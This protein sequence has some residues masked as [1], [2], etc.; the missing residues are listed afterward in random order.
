MR[1][2]A[3]SRKGV[4][5]RS[6]SHLGTEEDVVGGL[7]AEHEGVVLVAHLILVAAEAAAAPDAG[8]AQP[9]Q[10]LLQDTVTRKARRGV[11]M[12]QPP[13]H[14]T[15]LLQYPWLLLDP[16]HWLTTLACMHAC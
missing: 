8:R 13:G 16:G 15:L 9:R 3:Q 11:P 10:R 6:A 7:H 14:A 4:E 5:E 2:T 1:L 12:L